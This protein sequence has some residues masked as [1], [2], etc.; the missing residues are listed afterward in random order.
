MGLLDRLVSDLIKQS[1]GYN[2]RRI[3]RK[4]GGGKLLMAGGAAL[5]GALAME[6]MNQGQKAGPAA[7]PSPAA[8]PTLPPVPTPAAPL[9][10]LPPLPQAAPETAPEAE[11]DAEALPPD[12]EYAIVRTLIAAALADG[13]LADEE[14]KVI[15]ER[16]DEAGLPAE[17]QRQIHRDLVLPPTPSEL[18]E[19]APST[20]EREVLYSFATLMIHSDGKVEAKETEWLSRLAA[21]LEIPEGRARELAA[22]V[23]AP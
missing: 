22:Q 8:P 3:V 10:P 13:H 15:L 2:P 17:R 16:V 11:K 4:I 7:T 6:K 21:T 19:L 9:P 12:L 1:T 18:A 20:E 5:A 14:K 23:A